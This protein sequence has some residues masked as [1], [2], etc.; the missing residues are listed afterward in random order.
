VVEERYRT[1]VETWANIIYGSGDGTVPLRSATQG[2]SDGGVPA[3]PGG[4]NVGIH[5]ACGI[6]H[7]ALPGDPGVDARIEEFILRGKPVQGPESNCPYS[8]ATIGVFK[9]S[10]AAGQVV[11]PPAGSVRAAPEVLSIADAGTRGLLQVI[12][13]G[14]H[15]TIVLNDRQPVSLVLKGAGLA[16]QVQ[17]IASAGDGK[18]ESYVS[19]SGAVTIGTTGAVTRAGKVL[20]PIVPKRAAPVTTASVRRKGRVSTVR[21]TAR[22]PNGIGATFYQIGKGPSLRYLHPLR[23]TAKQVKALRFGSI[24]RF[25]VAERAHGVR[26][27]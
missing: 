1:G 14:G 4:A 5:Y 19:A 15:T 9:I 16:L 25:G 12:E 6:G 8:G 13:I 23:L 27:H 3:G 21:L 20:K 26:G 17:R 24:D 18:V 11:V 7:V 22:S 2:A 10:L